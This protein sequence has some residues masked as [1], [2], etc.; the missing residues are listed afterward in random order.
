MRQ[1]ELNMSI[2]GSKK[3]VRI[4]NI[5][6]NL[7]DLDMKKLTHEQNK[8]I[9]EIER[10]QA[11]VENLTGNLTM[12]NMSDIDKQFGQRQSLMSNASQQKA[13]SGLQ[14]EIEKYQKEIELLKLKLQFKHQIMSYKQM[15]KQRN[16]AM[17]YPNF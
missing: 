5:D 12:G 17:Q 11:E 1:S 16:L 4:N 3:S 8:D 14:Y 15:E 7:E 2:A 10:L 6:V 13:I 9:Q